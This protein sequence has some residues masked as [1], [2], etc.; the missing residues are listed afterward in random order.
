[1]LQYTSPRLPI[2][3][4]RCQTYVGKLN[5]IPTGSN[6]FQSTIAVFKEITIGNE[7]MFQWF[8]AGDETEQQLGDYLVLEDVI[9]EE[10]LW[11]R[12]GD[13]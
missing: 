7:T 10:E 5:Q 3:L 2:I 4:V 6:M 1:M 13:C 9:S 8:R 12:L 11:A